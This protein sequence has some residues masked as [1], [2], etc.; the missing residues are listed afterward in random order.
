M[1]KPYHIVNGDVLK[2]RFPKDIPGEL[3]V[4]R[5]CLVD[6]EVSGNNLDEI[7]QT[8]ARFLSQHYKGVSEDAYLEKT[9]PEFEKIKNLGDHASIHLWFEDDLFCQVNLWFVIHLLK[10]S[11]NRDQV[12]LLRPKVHTQ[13]GFSN[14]DETQLTGLYRNKEIL[15]NLDDFAELWKRYQNNDTNELLR[16]AKGLKEPYPFVLTAVE[17][18]IERIPKPNKLDRPSRTLLEIIEELKTEE[19]GLVFEEFSKRESIYGFGDVQV[20]RLFNALKK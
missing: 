20:K 19:F 16:I 2:E 8:R 6:G 7:F 5:E 14:L 13:Y 15:K 10:D 1:L 11:V 12:F 18:H 4:A 9:V 17:A 3:I